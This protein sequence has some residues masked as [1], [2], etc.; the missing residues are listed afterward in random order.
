M[1]DVLLT[2]TEEIIQLVSV[3]GASQG[4]ITTAVT[5]HN[6]STTAHGLNANIFA[7]LTGAASPSAGNV[8]ATAADIANIITR[9]YSDF[10]MALR[11][12]AYYKLNEAAGTSGAG[13]VIDSSG[14]A[15]H[16]TPTAVTFGVT[17]IGDGNSAASVNGSTSVIDCYSAGLAAAF[18]G[19]EVGVSIWFKVAAASVWTDGADRDI[20]H[21]S[22]N[23]GFNEL[24]IFKQSTNNTLLFLWRSGGV[25]LTAT[26]TTNSTDW[27]HCSIVQSDSGNYARFYFNGA[28]V[29]ADQTPG[30]WSGALNAV[31]TTIGSYTNIPTGLFIGSIAHVAVFQ[32]ALNAAQVAMLYQFGVFF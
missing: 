27:I 26:V 4:D 6:A 7:A 14:N 8:L 32:T 11:P 13:S 3:S 21:W 5:A 22:V 10:I 18:T 28:Q 30:T 31:T 25:T 16:A 23:D 15:H 24:R 12:L 29:G 20:I 9:P 1:A 17:G 19:L 2:S